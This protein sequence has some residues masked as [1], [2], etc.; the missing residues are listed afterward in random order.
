MVL[1]VCAQSGILLSTGLA[2][3]IAAGL[4]AISP[5]LSYFAL[6]L[7][8]ELTVI[9]AKIIRILLIATATVLAV[10]IGGTMCAL[11]IA[12][13][14]ICGSK[15][16]EEEMDDIPKAIELSRAQNHHSFFNA[17]TRALDEYSDLEE[18]GALSPA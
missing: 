11:K 8:Y 1:F 5:V 12:A 16:E 18:Q 9:L 17:Q 14:L 2:T 6:E 3:G 7:A 10:A 4:V 13:E 15:E